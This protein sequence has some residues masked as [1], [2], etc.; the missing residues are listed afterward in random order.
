MLSDPPYVMIWVAQFEIERYSQQL[1]TEFQA[2]M[3]PLLEE[4]LLMAKK[5]ENLSEIHA[6]GMTLGLDL[7]AY[8]TKDF[9]QSASPLAEI[10]RDKFAGTANDVILHGYNFDA[11][12]IQGVFSG[13][14]VLGAFTAAA[15][16]EQALIDHHFQNFLVEEVPLFME[17]VAASFDMFPNQLRDNA[18]KKLIFHTAL[19]NGHINSVLEY[20]DKLLPGEDDDVAVRRAAR[21]KV[22]PV[23]WLHEAAIKSF[24]RRIIS[25][26]H[27]R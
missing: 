22:F 2:M 1:R 14:V 24:K 20:R 9:L 8:D 26:I 6:F 18:S 16:L 12:F 5:L 27:K 7:S 13:F 23:E 11:P 10:L 3:D 19:A 17:R 15:A 25:K 4:T 21:K